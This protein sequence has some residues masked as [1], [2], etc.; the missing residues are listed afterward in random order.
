MRLR[1]PGRL[2]GAGRAARPGGRARAARALPRAPPRRARALRRHG[3]EVHRRRGD[4]A[5]RRAGRARGRSRAG[6]PGGAR[7]PRLG[8][9]SRARSSRCGSGSTRARRSSRS[10]R[11]PS[12]GE[13]M[14]AG[15]VVN[16]AA[17]LQAAAPAE[18]RP[19]RRARPTARPRDAIDYRQARAGRRR[20]GKSEP[21]RGLGGAAGRARASASTS[22]SGCAAPLVGRARE[23]ELLVATLARVREERSPQL[24]TLVGVPGIGKSRLVV[25]LFRSGRAR[26]RARRTWRQGRSLPYGEGVTLLGARPRS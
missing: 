23:L 13:A 9:R 25:E 17:R 11:G 26:P 1:R 15:D 18:R 16:T 21:I 14:A 3:R 4:G 12:E 5:V 20:K 8:R 10:A 2:H 24:V 22:R 19:R 7:D 6:R